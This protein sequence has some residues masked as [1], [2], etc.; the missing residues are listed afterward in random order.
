[1]S[2]ESTKSLPRWERRKDARPSELAQAALEVFI[3]KGFAATRLDDVAARAGVSKGTLYL[4]F[5]SKD[6][7]FK[8][9]V[10]GAIVPALDEAEQL[11]ARF[12]GSASELLRKFTFGMWN[13]VLSGPAGGIPKL[14]LAE[15]KNF[16]EIADFYYE[17]VVKR[18]SALVRNA[19]DRGIR[20]GEFRPVNVDHA[21]HVL[22]APVVMLAVSRHSVDF[23][24]RENRDPNTY[25]ETHLDIALAGLRAPLP[26]G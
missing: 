23:C 22:I 21:A 20:T 15:A 13:V 8:E 2:A 16:P 5:D 19:I 3:D 14:M 18:A 9:V 26:P 1:M 4:Y 12:E 17:A 11:I 6:A 10:R 24:G 7:L 25:I